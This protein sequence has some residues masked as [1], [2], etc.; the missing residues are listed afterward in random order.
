[1]KN[2]QKITVNTD[3]TLSLTYKF[4]ENDISPHDDR[5]DYWDD[6]HTN[7]PVS[8]AVASDIFLWAETRTA[9][10][11]VMTPLTLNADGSYTWIYDDPNKNDYK[12]TAG[13]NG[14]DVYIHVVATLFG[15]DSLTGKS[16]KYKFE[17]FNGNDRV[18]ILYKF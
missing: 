12:S 14:S 17:D 7:V 16:S 3:G 18:W 9:P 15:K 10:P 8:I 4:N 1:M 11:I 13:K 2:F 6:N 5:V